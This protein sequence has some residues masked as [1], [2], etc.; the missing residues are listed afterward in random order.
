MAGKFLVAVDA[1]EGSE[2]ALNA[3]IALAINTNNSITIAHVIE[4]SPFSFHTPDEL[5]ERQKRREEELD[6][7]KQAMLLQPEKLPG[8][9]ARRS[10]NTAILQKRLR[11]WLKIQVPCKYSLVGKGN[12]KLVCFF[13]A[14]L[15]PH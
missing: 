4:W 2:R 10:S 5:A 7:A 12:L 13:L 11:H 8:S 6:R 3:A 9:R 14:A 15:R 1:S